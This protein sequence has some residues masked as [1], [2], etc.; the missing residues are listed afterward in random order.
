[1]ISTKQLPKGV[2]VGIF[3]QYG[4]N[5]DKVEKG[6]PIQLSENSDGTIPTF[7]VSRI[8]TTNKKYLKAMEVATRPYER[9]IK[10]D[11]LTD[12]QNLDIS[13]EVFVNAILLDWSDVKDEDLNVIP[14][15]KENAKK[16]MREI[17][18]LYEELREA[19]KK[20]KLFQDDLIEEQTKN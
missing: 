1:M 19:S 11:A 12:K 4:I 2:L 15:S 16:I 7:I 14:Y 18:E 8:S 9:L 10:A 5:Q 6:V 3:K 13:L 17:P 20:L